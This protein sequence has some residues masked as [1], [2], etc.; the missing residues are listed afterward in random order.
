MAWTTPMTFADGNALTAAQLNTHL[1]DNL[2]AT[3]MALASEQPVGQPGGHFVVDDLNSIAERRTAF[4]RVNDEGATLTSASFVDLATFGPTVT[5]ETGSSAIVLC[6]ARVW[7]DNGE[8]SVFSY[9]VS[10]STAIGAS[11]NYAFTMDGTN[12]AA[13]NQNRWHGALFDLTTSLNPGSNTFTMKYRSGGAGTAR[14]RWRAICV[15]PL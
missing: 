10:G 5:V 9:D 3:M 12:N 13:N 8:Q 4:Q 2:G 6:N 11:D 15:I 14:F 7:N 1:R